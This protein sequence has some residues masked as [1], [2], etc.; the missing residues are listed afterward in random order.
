MTPHVLRTLYHWPLDPFSRSVRVL[1]AEKKLSAELKEVSPW[2]G[3]HLLSEL[4]AFPTLPMLVEPG[5]LALTGTR[6]ILDFLDDTHKTPGLRPALPGDRA[7]MARI[8]DC[9][10]RLLAGEVGATLL[11]ERIDQRVRRIGSPDTR[12]L[13]AGF[14]SLRVYLQH[15]DA[16]ADR[17]PFI[18][19]P[20]F[21]LADIVLAAHLSCF[22]YFGDL[23]LTGHDGLATWY[24][25]MKS[26]PAFRALLAD[27]LP[28]APPHAHYA[29]LDG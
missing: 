11:A 7:E 18:A 23:D 1:L 16:L 29:S 22:D 19:G 2:D 8:I 5:G 28:G 4:T 26:R 20:T 24:L 15:F 12:R 27:S 21:S 13:R 9:V 6:V 10:E 3:G 14:D 17:R 25:R